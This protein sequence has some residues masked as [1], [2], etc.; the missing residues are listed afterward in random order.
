M[1]WEPLSWPWPPT[2]RSSSLRVLQLLCFP[3]LHTFSSLMGHSIGWRRVN[4]EVASGEIDVQDLP[5]ARWDRSFLHYLADK[6]CW[7]YLLA[8]DVIGCHYF[9]DG[10]LSN[11]WLTKLN[12]RQNMMGDKA[13]I[14]CYSTNGDI[15]QIPRPL[16]SLLSHCVHTS[17]NLY[18][19]I[20]NWKKKYPT[21]LL[22]LQTF[23]PLCMSS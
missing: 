14:W 13:W 12:G 5:T 15:F 1:P 20:Y 10:D 11:I 9:L 19:Y 6:A 23:L 7:H 22:P 18:I 3:S 2:A 8:C 16:C 17:W 21:W 4:G